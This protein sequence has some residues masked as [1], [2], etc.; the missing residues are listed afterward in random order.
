MMKNILRFFFASRRAGEEWIT[1]CQ[2][3][4]QSWVLCRGEQLL[5]TFLER[6]S[7]RLKL[8]RAGFKGQGAESAG[9]L[10]STWCSSTCRSTRKLRDLKSPA[11]I[12]DQ[13]PILN[14]FAA[15]DFF[16]GL[17][18]LPGKRSRRLELGKRVCDPAVLLFLSL[19]DPCGG[20]RIHVEKFGVSFE[21]G[22]AFS[23][24]G[25]HYGCC[26]ILFEV[27]IAGCRFVY[28]EIEDSVNCYEVRRGEVRSAVRSHC[29][30]KS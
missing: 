17:F 24:I 3:R 22:L 26:R 20:S 28:S 12:L 8:I 11:P 10:F 9:R 4:S 15:P 7:R 19:Q 5:L 27:T 23:V 14:D 25:Q 2:F 18:C 29:S 16:F 1:L 13:G 21:Y 6:G 30:C